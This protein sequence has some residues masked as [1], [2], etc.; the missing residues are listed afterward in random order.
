AWDRQ[1]VD[2]RSPLGVRRINDAAMRA[3]QSFLAS[4]GQPRQPY[5]ANLVF[6]SGKHP[7]RPVECGSPDCPTC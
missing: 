4:R 7:R 6:T 2:R 5:V 1:T 3:T